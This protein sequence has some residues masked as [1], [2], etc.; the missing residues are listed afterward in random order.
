MS[1]STQPVYRLLPTLQFTPHVSGSRR[2]YAVE[3]PQSGRFLR[4]GLAE[5]LVASGL[6]NGVA[7]Q[8][9][10]V[11]LAEH[12]FD[13]PRERLTAT[14]GWL[15]KQGLL[16]GDSQSNAEAKSPTGAKSPSPPNAK[17][18]GGAT[19]DPFFI[20]IPFLP[21]AFVERLAKPFTWCVSWPVGFAHALLAF[22]AIV[23]LCNSGSRFWSLGEKLFVEDGRLWWIVAWLVLKSAHEFG[24]AVAAVSTG[25]R[26]RSAG[27]HFI[28][29]APVPYVDVTD[30]W[31]ITNRRQRILVSAAGMLFESAVAMTA[32]LIAMISG[33]LSVQYLCAAVATLGTI[34]TLAFNGNPLMKYDGYYILSDLISRPNFWTDAQSASAAFLSRFTNPFDDRP[35][36]ALQS[37]NNAWIMVSYGL[38]TKLYRVLMLVGMAW[39]LLA[40][41]HGIGALVIAW[42]VWG[43]FVRPLWLKRQMTQLAQ[44]MGKAGPV[45]EVS[46]HRLQRI[47]ALV[48]LLILCGI[49]MLPSPSSVRAPGVVG[50]GQPTIVRADA[51][52]VLTALSI[53]DRQL[54]HTGD[55]IAQLE[56]PELK[57]ELQENRLKYQTSCE[58]ANA[59]R[60]RGELA[61]LQ[62][63]QAKIE[64]LAEHVTQLEVRAKQLEIRA[65][66]DGMVLIS[67]GD[68]I[69][70]RFVKAGAP[71]CLIVS[72]RDLEVCASASQ[73]DAALFSK[74]ADAPVTLS[75]IGKTSIRGKLISVDTRGSDQCDQQSLG[76]NYGG[77]LTVEFS[78]NE[79]GESQ[80]KFPKP[81]FEVK[82]ELFADARTDAWIPGQI[83][84]IHLNE[85]P[86]RLWQWAWEG[87]VTLL[88]SRTGDIDSSN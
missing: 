79:Q 52:G 3:D 38:T 51:E 66:C 42:A 84:W 1:A 30:L 65:P 81:R 67:A 17:P 16:V 72:P 11:V 9:I 88:Q 48:V 58:Q 21:G 82:A 14:V 47:Y 31:N 77:P 24:H 35:A 33:N 15:A 12:G 61:L 63:E 26:I 34:T 80:L 45:E 43:W 18:M 4:L 49:G 64:A 46:S 53:R 6:Q 70:G 41:W 10:T 55:L 68:R 78:K 8:Q 86:Q 28:F 5:Y 25:S 69:A 60:A 40:V 87:F 85:R 32:V 22:V 71:L 75:A 74:S 50:Y 27:I 36:K 7:P 76:A 2:W 20:R 54:I 73:R 56:N 13:N 62:A 37:L 39:W 59:L 23:V 57:V 29:L 19:F 83:A 44:K